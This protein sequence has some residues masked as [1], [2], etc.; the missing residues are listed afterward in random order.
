MHQDIPLTSRQYFVQ[1]LTDDT[2]P[3]S[4]PA[5]INNFQ[6]FLWLWLNYW[7]CKI[8]CNDGI[9]QIN[10]KPAK[11][12]LTFRILDL[13]FTAQKFFNAIVTPDV[14]N[15]INH[16]ATIFKKHNN[17]YTKWPNIMILTWKNVYLHS[18]IWRNTYLNHWLN[19][20]GIKK[21]VSRQVFCL[22]S[23]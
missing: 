3:K 11:W 13:V 14:F 23:K 9:F 22:I 18:C 7:K 12:A 15:R 2:D 20:L 19:L 16:I 4:S 5:H 10:I 21:S 1:T 17:F 8:P 6:P